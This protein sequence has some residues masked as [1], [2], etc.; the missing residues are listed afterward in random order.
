MQFGCLA[1]W[2]ARGGDGSL[3]ARTA[4]WRLASRL[5]ISEGVGAVEAAVLAAG[6]STRLRRSLPSCCMHVL[7]ICLLSLPVKARCHFDVA[8]HL[9]DGVVLVLEPVT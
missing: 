5:V 9:E 2:L 6:Q 1:A 3:S 7:L 8:G 4:R